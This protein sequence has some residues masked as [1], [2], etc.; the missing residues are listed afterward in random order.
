MGKGKKRP[1]IQA[2]LAAADADGAGGGG[3][4]ATRHA[5]IA[6]ERKRQKAADRAARERAFR[7]RH[8]ERFEATEHGDD[9]SAGVGGAPP[10]PA[11]RGDDDPSA[12]RWGWSDGSGG[13]A[14]GGYGGVDPDPD[15][16]SEPRRRK[17]RSVAPLAVLPSMTSASTRPRSPTSSRDASK[18]ASLPPREGRRRS[19]PRSSPA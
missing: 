10:D 5:E 14:G 11:S 8:P 17:P 9:P 1:W 7:E 3:G 16:P 18:E 19:A 15:L 12:S 6:R 13:G 2:K 4:E